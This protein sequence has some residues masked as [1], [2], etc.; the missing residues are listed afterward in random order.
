MVGKVCLN[1][2]IPSQVNV[3]SQ[4][5]PIV[6]IRQSFLA[7]LTFGERLMVESLRRSACG[8]CIHTKALGF[9][10]RPF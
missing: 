1:D 10:K 9:P 2:D 4:V 3:I 7:R 5:L 8:V 6:A